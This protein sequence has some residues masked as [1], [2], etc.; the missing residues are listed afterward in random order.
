MAEVVSRAPNSDKSW[1]ENPPSAGLVVAGATGATEPPKAALMP[2]R[3]E[4]EEAP[5]PGTE[6]LEEGDH[7][8]RE[9]GPF[10]PFEDPGI[11]VSD[12]FRKVTGGCADD[13]VVTLVGGDELRCWT[14]RA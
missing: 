1:S 7:E 5:E 13:V 3:E 6:K 12:E 8:E 10:L 11:A 14:G 9:E 4:M 2:D